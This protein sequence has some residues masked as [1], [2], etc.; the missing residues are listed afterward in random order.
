[1]G[2]HEPQPAPFLTGYTDT[3]NN[4]PIMGTWTFQYDS[5]NRLATA[6]STQPGNP[7]PN[8]CWSYDRGPRRQVFVAGV[9]DGFGNRT[10]QMSAS[11]AF[12]LGQGGANT[13]ST[14][15]NLGQ[16][17][18]A[19]YNVTTNGANNNQ[20][21][22]WPTLEPRKLIGCPILFTVSS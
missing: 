17:V 15:G 7:Y 16:N 18:W 1:M 19:Q 2:Y 6:T 20:M 10:D 14:T 21:D 11:V 4:Q 3:S 13:C 5:L 22:A 8:Y 9:G 12:A